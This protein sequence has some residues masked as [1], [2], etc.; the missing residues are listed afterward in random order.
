MS[1]LV[2]LKEAEQIAAAIGT[3]IGGGVK[4]IYVIR[5]PVGPF[6]AP[7]DGEKKFFHFDFKNGARGYN[8]GLI[9]D[10]MNRFPLTWPVN[11]KGEV[12]RDANTEPMPW[13][14]EE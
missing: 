3:N 8:A 4:R 12:D 1:Q 7:E 9:K 11:L 6:A 13:E 10:L 2:T 5:Y 14:V